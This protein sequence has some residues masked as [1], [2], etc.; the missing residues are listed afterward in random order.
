MFI[1]TLISTLLFSFWIKPMLV[2]KHIFKRNLLEYF[3]DIS[4]KIFVT[5]ICSFLCW[6]IG[7]QLFSEYTI[8]NLMLRLIIC[9][10]IPNGL[11]VLFTFKTKEFKYIMGIIRSIIIKFKYIVT[12]K[13][14]IEV[15]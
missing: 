1:G 8:L 9:I 7:E 11:I 13:F 5:I 6:I 14:K 2:Y 15:N 12:N 10:V 4:F 3:I